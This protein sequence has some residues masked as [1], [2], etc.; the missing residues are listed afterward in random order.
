MYSRMIEVEPQL[1]RE[2]VKIAF[3]GKWRHEESRI[4]KRS[5]QF[6]MSFFENFF[7]I[8]ILWY[9]RLLGIK[10][11]QLIETPVPILTRE[12]AIADCNRPV[13]PDKNSIFYRGDILV[14]R[15]E[16]TFNTNKLKHL[17]KIDIRPEVK[18]GFLALWEREKA[19]TPAR[20]PVLP[21]RWMISCGEDNG[22]WVVSGLA[23][24]K[25][26]KC[27]PDAY[28]LFEKNGGNWVEIPISKQETR[29]ASIGFVRDFKENNA[30]FAKY[31]LFIEKERITTGRQY[32]LVAYF[33]DAQ[34][35]YLLPATGNTKSI[36]NSFLRNPLP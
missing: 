27:E 4:A 5:G 26:E 17:E 8:N 34:K 36:E 21:H 28:F 6:G 3:E 11:L 7:R 19:K 30:L 10:N 33:H 15:L 29:I 13:W 22:K 12:A 35:V 31:R 32:C 23:Y 9:F 14:V 20:L 18:R 24:S 2:N 1:G 16:N 25:I